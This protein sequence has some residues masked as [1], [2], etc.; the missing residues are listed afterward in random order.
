MWFKVVKIQKQLSS[1]FP[2]AEMSLNISPDECIAIG[3]AVQA[4][5]ITKDV[6]LSGAVK[7]LA[8]SRDI[9]AIFS[10]Y[11]GKS[12]LIY[13]DTAIPLRKSVSVP[14]PA[15]TA[16]VC[17]KIMYSPDTVLAELKLAV[18]KQSKLYLGVHVHRDGSSHFTLTDK[19]TDKSTDALLKQQ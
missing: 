2:G 11:G 8:V 12:V 1:M 5:L 15:D 7:M 19:H 17:V 16:E 4:S 9:L 13:Q 10:P 3:A 6:T 18:E 14:L